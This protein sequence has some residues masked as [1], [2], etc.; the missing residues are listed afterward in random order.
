MNRMYQ[1]LLEQTVT[2]QTQQQVRNGPWQ[3][4]AARLVLVTVKKST[5]LASCPA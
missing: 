4:G 1:V 2:L 3:R 5:V